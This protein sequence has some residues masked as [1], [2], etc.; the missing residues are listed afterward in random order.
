MHRS[1]STKY[2]RENDLARIRRI[3]SDR[4]AE[5]SESI[6]DLFVAY[7]TLYE[8]DGPKTS[9]RAVGIGVFYFEEDKL[10]TDIFA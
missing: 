1:A 10:E 8:S 4:L 5:F 6:D 7:E 9:S 2:V 3:S